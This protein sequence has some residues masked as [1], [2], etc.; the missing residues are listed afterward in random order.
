[1]LHVYL[2]NEMRHNVHVL[3]FIMRRILA[4]QLLPENCGV[5]RDF[6]LANRGLRNMADGTRIE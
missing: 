1:M 2:I 3:R 4:P 6:P 5:G